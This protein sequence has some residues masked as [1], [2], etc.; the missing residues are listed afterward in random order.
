MALKLAL[1]ANQ[2]SGSGGAERVVDALRRH[3]AEVTCFDV[4]GLEEAI[5]CDPERLAVAGGDGSIAPA[6]PALLEV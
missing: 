5:A 2:E 3:G 4:G 6:L 1:L